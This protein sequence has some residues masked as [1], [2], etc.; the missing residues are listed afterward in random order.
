MSFSLFF[1]ILADLRNKISKEREDFDRASKMSAEERKT[2][3]QRRAIFDNLGLT[4]GEATSKD[5]STTEINR[6]D[7]K[8]K[9]FLNA[10]R[11]V[12]KD[13]VGIN[14]PD[15]P[16]PMDLSLLF[17]EWCSMA[18]CDDDESFLFRDLTRK[19][20]RLLLR[21]ARWNFAGKIPVHSMS[22][23]VTFSNSLP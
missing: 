3:K 11:G 18:E 7:E 23:F 13:Y 16:Q 9:Q 15:I 10:I 12:S 21:K 2:L 17:Q 6:I 4:G 19:D 20:Q 5:L 22:I 1:S 8:Y 14:S